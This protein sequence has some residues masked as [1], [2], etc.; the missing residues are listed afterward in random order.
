[1]IKQS[2]DYDQVDQQWNSPDKGTFKKENN[3]VGVDYEGDESDSLDDEKIQQSIRKANTLDAAGVDS[4]L[5]SMV[6]RKRF[7]YTFKDILN[8]VFCC[9][10][11]RDL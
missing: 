3:K 2:K 11:I 1:M 6:T 10:F 5:V 4:L 7:V 8:Y 9:F